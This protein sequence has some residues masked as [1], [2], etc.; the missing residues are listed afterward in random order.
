[1]L[2]RWGRTIDADE[3]VRVA[4]KARAGQA[5]AGTHS[6]LMKALDVRAALRLA[7]SHPAF[8]AMVARHGRM[9][10]LSDLTVIQMDEDPA[11]R[12][13]AL[14][15]ADIVELMALVRERETRY[16]DRTSIWSWLLFRHAAG[17]AGARRGAPR[18]RG[19][20]RAAGPAAEERLTPG[21]CRPKATGP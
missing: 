9:I 5:S 7:K 18:R 19:A 3:L 8:A 10:D 14:A 13:A 6:L 12:K 11:F 17:A 1:M 16:P 20:A 4:R 21:A 2:A 15:D